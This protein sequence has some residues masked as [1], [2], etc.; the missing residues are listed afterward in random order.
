MRS[1][2]F[3]V[4][5]CMQAL[6]EHHWEPEAAARALTGSED[7][8]VI[9]RVERKMSRFLQSIRRS[10]AEGTEQR[11]FNNLPAAYHAALSAAIDHLAK[12]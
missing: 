3:P 5:R 8:E 2:G 10:I 12:R 11:L 4:M 9:K 1:L 6:A 7:P